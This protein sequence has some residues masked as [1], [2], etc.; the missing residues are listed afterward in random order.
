MFGIIFFIGQKSVVFRLDEI[1]LHCYGKEPFILPSIF[2][3]LT[4]NPYRCVQ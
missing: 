1:H 3:Q 4:S 2:Y